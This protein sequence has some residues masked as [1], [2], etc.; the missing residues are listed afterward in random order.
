MISDYY[1]NNIYDLN[2][3]VVYYARVSTVDESQITSIINQTNYFEN[4]I[5]SINNWLLVGK[6]IDE[7]I[8]GKSINNRINFRRMIE[9]GLLGK[10]DLILTK[11]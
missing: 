2:L 8:S 1:Q 4:Y 9:D 6:Y 7:G 3:R 11:K 5:K 10:Y